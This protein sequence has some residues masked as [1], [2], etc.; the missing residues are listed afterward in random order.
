MKKN[1]ITIALD[2]AIEDMGLPVGHSLSFVD[3]LPTTDDGL[4]F[5][6]SQLSSV[7][8]KIYET[9]YG[10]I[11]Y[12]DLVPVD[13]SDPEWADESTYISYDAVT[14]GK[15][16]GSNAKDIPEA[17]LTASKSSIP[18]FYGAIGYKYSLDELRKSQQLR[19]PIDANKAKASYRGFEEHAQ[20][21]CFFG[22]ADRGTTGLF[23]GA[24]IQVDNSTVD[25]ATATGKEIAGDVDGVLS[26][27]WIGSKEVHVPD[28]LLIPSNKWS[29][30]TSRN[31]D[32]G[33]NMSI[34]EYI[35]ANNLYTSLTG[36][37][38]N[39]KPRIQLQDLGTAGEGRMMAYELNDENLTF[40]IPMPWRAI[41]PQPEGVTVKVPAEYKMAAGTEFRYPGC[42][43]Y[44][45]FA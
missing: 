31:M 1:K 35:K 18:L 44:R 42:A 36:K 32:T 10:H 3:G 24:N 40:K 37:P 41:A 25:W 5:Y 45:D 13:S 15:F 12:Q 20:R 4:A 39:I 33:I 22:D 9:K 21:V 6:I 23:N 28:T 7:E 29:I 14:I 11:V 38:L 2:A 16:I 34:L 17:D 8:A 43:A 19:M 26:A 30:L 27:V